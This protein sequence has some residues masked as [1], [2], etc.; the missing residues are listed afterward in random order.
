MDQVKIIRYKVLVEHAPIQQV[1]REF[2]I[3]RNTVKRYLRLSEPRRIEKEPRERPIFAKVQGRLNALL[4]ESSL[5]TAGKQRLTATRL[6]QMLLGEG[7]K[8]GLTLVKDFVHEWKRQRQEV[9]IPLIYYPGELAEVDFFD[10]YVLLAGV[11]TKVYLFLLRLMYSGRDFACLYPRQDQVTF[12]DGHVQ[13]FSY[14]GKVPQRI[15]YDNLK[16]A[17]TK[18][19]LGHQRQLSPRFNALSAHYL[20]EPNFC[21]PATGHDKGGVESRGKGI[22]LQHL[23]PLPTGSSLKEINQLLMTRLERQFA[24]R[25]S[26][27]G[28]PLTERWALEQEK[29]ILLSEYPFR[30]VLTE[31]HTASRQ[32]MI[33][34]DSAWYSVPDHWHS[35][36]L[37]VEIG[38]ETLTVIGPDGQI[39]HPRQRPG[40]KSIDYRSY[41]RELSH[42]PQAVRQVIPA[43]LQDL[44]EPYSTVWRQLVD[45]HTPLAAARLFARILG[46]AEKEGVESIG[47]QIE[48][49]LKE[50]QPILLALAAKNAR[51]SVLAQESIPK[52][53]RE[54]EIESGCAADYDELLGRGDK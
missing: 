6:H 31:F 12:L 1:A 36:E 23:V 42:K 19:C 43:L 28:Q 17:V 25:S 54:I 41:L 38:T 51:E 5:W 16:A 29:M 53:L 7:F 11:V 40:Q 20:F 22:R 48:E 32:S 26:P 10:V 33:R 18:I 27:D 37:T 30:A 35:L 13:A 47:K 8:V 9:F 46:Y 24:S 34:V 14:L 50:R 3:S 2:K 15:A 45:E 49:A 39:Q 52:R 4:Q 21:R 44:G